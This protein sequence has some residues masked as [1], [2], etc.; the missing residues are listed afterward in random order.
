MIDIVY[1]PEMAVPKIKEK[2]IE[3]IE[4][5]LSEEAW[6]IIDHIGQILAE[7]YV[8]LLKEN[9]KEKVEEL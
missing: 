5:E 4:V 3:N 8:K 6:A 7:E 9:P 2:S 1:H